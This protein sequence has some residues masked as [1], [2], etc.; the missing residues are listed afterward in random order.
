MEEYNSHPIDMLLYREEF[1]N[2]EMRAIFN[3]KNIIKKWLRVDAAVARVEAELGI[4]PLAAAEEIERKATGDFVKVSRV[5]ELARQKGLDIAAEF[6]ALAEVC[7]EG[8]REYIRMGVGGI[9][10]YDTAWALLIKEALELIYRDLDKLIGILVRLTK[11]HRSTLTV[12]RTFGQHEGP[13]T[14]GYKTAMWAKELY[15]CRCLLKEG[16]KHYLVGKA[17]GTIGNLSSLE[18]VYP[19]KGST[20]EEEVC[21]KLGLNCPDITILF[22]RR[23]FMQ[24]VIN[25]TYI[26]NAIDNIATE[27]FNRQR[28][29]IGEL[30]E[31]FKKDQVAS[32]V[33]PHKRNPYGCNILS[34]LAELVRA[35][36]AAILQST[37]FD[38][39]DHRR[40][41]VESSVI[42]S[43]F[44]YVSGMLQR[45]VFICGN[46]LINS[47][48][49]LENLNL[50]KGL[51]FS[52]LV[53][54]ALATRGLG[55]YTAYALV[56]EIAQ[57][58]Y[59]EG[60]E[61]RSVLRSHETVR[62]YLSDEDIDELLDP[63]SSLGLIESQI[64]KTLSEIE[65]FG[66]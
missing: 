64:D 3:E 65:K 48:R 53:A 42:P 12:G 40:M 20:L 17:S 8:A 9:D 6:T 38:E 60:I 44:I 7:E 51:N 62:Q 19:G 14:F 56:R 59:R 23:R 2:E 27:I 43:T 50:L 1:G 22:S 66:L 35:N 16:Q 39:R 28:P 52:E 29:E 31:P 34:G 41:P 46:L 11:E 5:A 32:T 54:T 10:N 47:T 25:L 37:W 63:K 15:Q 26:A 57:T 24:V 58:V 61:F 45:A 21:K 13:I 30:Q 33:S 55:R 36:A 18:K 49:M 4:I